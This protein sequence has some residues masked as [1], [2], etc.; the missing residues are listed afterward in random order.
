MKP[1]ACLTASSLS[2]SA[3]NAPTPSRIRTQM[4][5][6]IFRRV[7]TLL[8][9]VH[10]SQNITMHVWAF[11][12]GLKSILQD[13]NPKGNLKRIVFFEGIFSPIVEEILCLLFNPFGPSKFRI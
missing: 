11:K 10:L 4:L 7:I 12:I 9:N 1:L 2:Y 6:S 3:T 8:A 13:A 5:M